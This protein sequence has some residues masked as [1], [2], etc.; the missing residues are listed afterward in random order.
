M[1]NASE[2]T[3]QYGETSSYGATTT[4]ATSLSET[5]TS[6]PLGGLTEGTLYHYRLV[7]EDEEGN[8]FAGDDYTFETLPVPQVQNAKVQQVAGLPTATLRVLW[9]SNTPISTIVTYYPTA[10]PSAANDYIALAL[11]ASHEVILKNLQNATAYTIVVKG[12]DAAGNEAL[13]T[14]ISV[15]TAVD[16]RAPE[17]LNLNVE[18]I[19]VGVGTEARAQLIVSWDTDEPAT[20][21]VAYAEGTGT[22]Y[23]QSTQEESNLTTNHVVTI[24]GLTPSKIYH[25]QALSDDTT[26]NTG[27]SFDTVVV[28]PKSTKA[29]LNLVIDNLSKTFGFLKGFGSN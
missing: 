14:P 16:F 26:G 4:I 10:N 25:L 23:N 8:T 20:T 9:T 13:S 7:A 3:V 28:T 1:S 2:V 19:L 5:T 15:T 22:T 18:S 12:K 6:I 27:K 24:T 17:I 11:T 21:Q 29:A